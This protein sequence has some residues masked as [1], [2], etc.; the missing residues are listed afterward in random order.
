M[1][2]DLTIVFSSYKSQNLFKEI[3]KTINDYQILII[4]NSNDFSIK[5]NLEKEFNN[6]EVLIPGENLGLAKSYN[7]G[8]QKAKTKFVFLNNPD[9]KISNET[10]S[11]LLSCAKKIEKFGIISPTYTDERI[12]KNY[13]IFN[14]TKL[15][16]TNIPNEFDLVEVDL[17]DNNFLI[18]K[19]VIGDYKF[20]ENFFL[21][22]ETF[23]FSLNLKKKGKKLYVSNKLKF[24]HAGSSSLPSSYDFF[25]KKTRSFHYNWGKFYYFRKNYNYFYA[26][27]KIVPN[28]I[29][30]FKKIIISLIKF[31][32]KNLLLAFLEFLGIMSGIFFLK[33]FYR[34]K[35]NLFH[36]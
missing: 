24:H 14:D 31:D 10:I 4:E 3:L 17:I 33:S 8:I 16:N 36:N 11:N 35:D 7:L 26:L 15:D 18:N 1:N 22:F 34:P 19:D 5:K 23:D 21:F 30:S 6:V 32:F 28:L 20:D 27:K 29:R 13:E 9:I 25:V 2:K 12:F